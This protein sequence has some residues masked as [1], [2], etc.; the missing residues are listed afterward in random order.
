M[1]YIIAIYIEKGGV[2]KTTSTVHL[3]QACGRRGLHVLVVD[4]DAQSH[5]TRWLQRE[6]PAL[7]LNEAI[8]EPARVRACITPSR[9][10]GV[11]LLPGSRKLAMVAESVLKQD[12]EGNP[13]NSF[14]VLKQLLAGLD[15]YD[16][17]LI[18]CSP[19][20]SVLN[21]NAIVAADMILVPTDL[22]DLG[23][24]GITRMAMTVAQMVTNQL[25]SRVPAL[26]VLLTLVETRTSR[27]TDDVRQRIAEIGDR[28]NAPYIVLSNTIRYRTQMKGI[29]GRRATAF[30][31]I[32]SGE[33]RWKNLKPVT[34]DY[35]AAA[36]ELV[37]LV[38]ANRQVTG[39]R[40]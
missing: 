13:R 35:L 33:F 10:P 6:E 5:A 11:D 24:D 12:D 21:A 1:A 2:G 25:L 38:V 9:A 19:S 16:L 34:D 17:V 37:S 8:R 4:L 40:S 15:E 22:A 28:D 29:F 7:S 32:E 23:F 3:A 18:D 20:V 30:D 36:A 26:V 27:T 39:A 31:L 14:A